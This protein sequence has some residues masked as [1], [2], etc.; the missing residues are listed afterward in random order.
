MDHLYI[1]TVR[2]YLLDLQSK[3]VKAFEKIEGSLFFKELW[4]SDKSGGHGLS[5]WIEN[6]AVFERGCV[7]FSHVMGIELPKSAHFSKS[8]APSETPWQA[9]GIS[10]VIHPKNPYAPTVH[11]NIRMFF[12]E[13]TEKNG[14]NLFWFGGGM[15]LTPFYIYEEDIL[16]FHKCCYDALA[17]HG[18]NYY[19][20]YKKWCDNYFFLKHRNET[21]GVGGIFFDGLY[22]PGFYKSFS[23][24]KS[25]GNAFLS[26]YLPILERRKVIKYGAR[27][28]EF[29]AYRRARYVEFNLILDRGILFGLKSG[30]RVESI[31]LSMPPN[32]MWS[33][34][35]KPELGSEEEKLY[36]YL[37]PMI[38]V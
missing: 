12:M 2:D 36:K 5:Y 4:K 10:V 15:D 1:C 32:A 14:K 3:I 24:A 16:H 19:Q 37:K 38:W 11:M 34:N 26:S 8:F 25:V 27:E 28:R 30:G 29:Q 22:T 21:R 31:F 6:G 17:F 35:W 9:L 7:L 13:K 23:I 33:Y 20:D 18:S